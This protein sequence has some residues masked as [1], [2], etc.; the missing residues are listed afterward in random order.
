MP[1]DGSGHGDNATELD[2]AFQQNITH[3]AGGEVN[4]LPIR[5]PVASI[6]YTTR[7]H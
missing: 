3:G 2:P 6:S 4:T 7:N 5:L 1:R